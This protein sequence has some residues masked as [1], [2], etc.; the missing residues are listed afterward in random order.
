MS[1]RTVEGTQLTSHR[2]VEG[3]QL[4]SHLTNTK[5]E[6]LVLCVGSHCSHALWCFIYTPSC[7]VIFNLYTLMCCDVS[8]IHP[9]AFWCFIYTPSSVVM[10]HSYVVWCFIYTPSC[11][12]MFHLWNITTHELRTIQTHALWCFYET[13]QRMSLY[14]FLHH[15]HI[16]IGTNYPV[17]LNIF[18]ISLLYKRV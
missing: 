17:L 2:T 3:T 1:H 16:E 10:F 18:H 11:V 5:R 9:D 12:V 8:F 13:S 7:V 6:G 14:W 4:I 15:S